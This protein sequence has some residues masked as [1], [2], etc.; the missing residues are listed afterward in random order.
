MEAVLVALAHGKR[1]LSASEYQNLLD[2]VGFNPRILDFGE[3]IW[4]KK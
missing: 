2:K 1:E 3:K 4:P